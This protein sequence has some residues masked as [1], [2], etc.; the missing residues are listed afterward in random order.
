[1]D[2]KLAGITKLIRDI[3]AAITAPGPAA[4][5][6][7]QDE[8]VVGSASQAGTIFKQNVSSWNSFILEFASTAGSHTIIVEGNNTGL[9]ADFW[10]PLS[11]YPLDVASTGAVSSRPVTTGYSAFIYA[12]RTA[13]IRVRISTYGGSGTINVMLTLSS[14]AAH[15]GPYQTNLAS[16]VNNFGVAAGA[17]P[18]GVLAAG[19][20]KN[21]NAI[22]S[23]LTGKR[24]VI[25]SYSDAGQA[26]VIPYSVPDQTFS[27]SPPASG[28]SNSSAAVVVKAAPG[29][30]LR[31]YI[32]SLDICHDVL[33]G[34]AELVI[35]DG[36]TVIR[37]LK[38]QGGAALTP[39]NILFKIPL[40]GSVNQS[41]SVKLETAVTGSVYINVSGYVAV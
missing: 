38:L 18:Y 28:I 32:S 1:M 19:I 36:S 35:L 14:T 31:N 21:D 34:G 12:K 13:F 41:I 7:P 11:G 27:Y 6:N 8:V 25:P 9:D 20:S 5:K 10:Y 40:R 2:V 37:R 39:Q 24:Y 30:G 33:G 16:N 26:L 23:D 4:V 3:Y 22:G 15:N 29:A 17:S